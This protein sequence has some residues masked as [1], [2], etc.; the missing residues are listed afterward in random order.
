MRHALHVG[1]HVVAYAPVVAADGSHGSHYRGVGIAGQAFLA[2]CV[3]L[4]D[5]VGG[6]FSVEDLWQF[7]HFYV[8]VVGYEATL[9]A[10][11]ATLCG[12]GHH[13]AALQAER[14]DAVVQFLVGQG[15]HVAPV[16]L[17]SEVVARLAPEVLFAVDG[18]R[19]VGT[20]VGQNHTAARAIES[21][22]AVHAVVCY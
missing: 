4:E 6:D 18:Q 10:V 13:V 16:V 7:A 5:A 19:L 11:A 17:Q 3:P 22:L 15:H 1:L 21:H 2:C 9:V 20:G 12:K 14:A 8:L